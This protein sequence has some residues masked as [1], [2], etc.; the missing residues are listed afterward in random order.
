MKIEL[1]QECNYIREAECASIMRQLTQ[2][3]PNYYVPEVIDELSGSQV[4]TSEFITGLTIDQCVDLDQETRNQIVLDFLILLFTEL[5]QFRYMQTDPNWAN[6][7]YNLD[8]K[9]LG[10]LD[11]GATREYK[12]EF[13]NTY[14]KVIY[15][16]IWLRPYVLSVRSLSPPKRQPQKN[17][18]FFFGFFLGDFFLEFLKVF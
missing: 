18:I 4:F 3:F 5:F 1:E 16:I 13:V 9:Q 15:I 6:F 11:F 2:P 14:F 12:P 7:L 17:L 10:L 8:T